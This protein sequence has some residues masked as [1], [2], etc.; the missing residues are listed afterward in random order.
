[1]F[2]AQVDVE[3]AATA[4]DEAQ[5][6]EQK[7]L[8]PPALRNLQK[9]AGQHDKVHIAQVLFV[10]AVTACATPPWPTAHKN[11]QHISGYVIATQVAVFELNIVFIAV[12]EAA[13]VQVWPGKT[14]IVEKSEHLP[15]S[16]VI[17][18]SKQAP[19]VLPVCMALTNLMALNIG[20]AFFPY[21][22]PTFADIYSI[23]GKS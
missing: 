21:Y 22:Y 6:Q 10:Y 15:G 1:V 5:K 8:V 14:I 23:S 3:K 11:L 19:D 12:T 13:I 17:K 4:F 2:R 18:D 9:Q 16:P 20:M 7:E